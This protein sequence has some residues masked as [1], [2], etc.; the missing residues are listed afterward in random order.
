[1]I[2]KMEQDGEDDGIDR[3]DN[4]VQLPWTPEQMPTNE[5][6]KKRAE[7]RKEQGQKL[8]DLMARKRAE[9]RRNMENELAD[10]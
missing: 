1:M 4:I 10:L 9:K 2:A 7:M 8:K 6:L 5:E 3:E